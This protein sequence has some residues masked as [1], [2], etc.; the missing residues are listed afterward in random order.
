[1][2]DRDELCLFVTIHG[3]NGEYLNVGDH[4]PSNWSDEYVGTLLAADAVGVPSEAQL[5][6][7]SSDAIVR[8]SDES[9]INVVQTGVRS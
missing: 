9:E 8:A 6:Q 5:E 3:P 2:L 7:W 4:L 1:M